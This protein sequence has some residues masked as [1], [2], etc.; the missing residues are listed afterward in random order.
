VSEFFNRAAE[1]A[2]IQR[3]LDSNKAE[4]VIVY[5]RRGSGKSQLLLHALSDRPALYYQA[6]AEVIA[7]QLTDLTSELA[8]IAGHNT[9]VGRIDSLGGLLAA[10]STLA[11]QDLTRPFI[12]VIDEFPYLAQAATG[13]ESI[14][15]KWWDGARAGTPNLKLFLA[16]SHVSWMQ[17]HTLGEHG[18]L[19]NRRTRQI[20]VLPLSYEHAAAF[21]PHLSARDRITAYAI[22]GGLPGYLRELD[23]ALGL[24][25]NLSA[26][27][28]DPDA[29]LFA[30]PDWLRFTDLRADRV[31][32]SLVRCIAMGQQT[33]GP[34]ARA[35]GR[36]SAND[37][38]G[39][40]GRLVEMGIVRRMS[41]MNVHPGKRPVPRYL[42]ADPF[43]AFWYRFV[44]G[45]RSMLRRGH[46]ESAL[47][48]IRRDIDDY[49]GQ[50]V[51]EHV[52]REWVWQAQ[53]QGR[54]PVDLDLADVG[55]WWGGS[56]A[57]QDEVDVVALSSG[58]EAVL[59]G[60]CKWSNSP[61]DLHDLA[62]LRHAIDISRKD[63]NPVL[64][65]WRVCFSRGGFHPDL[66]DEAADP[67]N[68]ILLVGIDQFYA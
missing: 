21:C 16:G 24:W 42:V 68:R 53:R 9:V 1:M 59:F 55:S 63:L 26:T 57:E 35:V 58:L 61:M 22:W 4:L 7:Q 34:I 67:A 62:G 36:A 2:T 43:L 48:Q 29:R 30:E 31:Y 56:K 50:Y 44:D 5:G 15:Q 11:R 64:S 65:P 54:L 17:E 33:P 3:A 27:V 49:I 10:V 20:E 28:L 25:E 18:P 66:A 38:F 32:T 40:L 45:R 51:F 37:I 14:L 8:R 19:Q 12:L 47:Q 41:P 52:C 13:T 6:T 39:Q 23:P 60:E 46:R